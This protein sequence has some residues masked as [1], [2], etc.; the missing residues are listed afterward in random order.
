MII[1]LEI[2]NYIFQTE[3]NSLIKWRVPSSPYN[4][5]SDPSTLGQLGSSSMTMGKL[6]TLFM[7]QVTPHLWNGTIML[8]ISWGSCKNNEINYLNHWAQCLAQSKRSINVS[9]SSVS[10]FPLPGLV[11]SWVSLPNA[12]S[13]LKSSVLFH[14]VVQG[15]VVHMNSDSS[16]SKSNKDPLRRT[17]PMLWHI[18]RIFRVWKYVEKEAS[19]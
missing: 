11:Y 12:G 15:C 3:R 17:Q 9:V 1:N 7:T 13:V 14:R 6:L 8:P 19:R 5:W 4:W 18:L 16:P 2:W 10:E